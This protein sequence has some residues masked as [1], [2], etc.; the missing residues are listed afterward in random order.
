MIYKTAIL[1]LFKARDPNKSYKIYTNHKLIVASIISNLKEIGSF[2]LY[3]R[4]D[5]LR[6]LRIIVNKF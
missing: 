5:P 4:N 6:I 2:K 1:E 3:H